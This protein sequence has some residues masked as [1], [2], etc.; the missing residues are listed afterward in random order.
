MSPRERFE[1][2]VALNIVSGCWLWTLHR[3]AKGYGQ[4]YVSRKDR[5]RLAHR[6]SYE[7]YVGK[8]P[9]GMCVL[10]RC[11][12]PPCVNPA[13]LFLGTRADNH[14]DMERKGRTIKGEAHAN[15]KLTAEQVES[16][17]KDTRLNRV[18]AIEHGVGNATVAKIK[19]GERWKH[20]ME[21]GHG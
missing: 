14:A 11:D 16:I 4:F 20:L 21:S 5:A 12:N 3:N 6:V 7:M 19:R 17:R 10:H 1:A 15:A 13:H 18:I 2:S 9:D 8:V